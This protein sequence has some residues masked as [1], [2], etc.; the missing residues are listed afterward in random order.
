[1]L[2]TLGPCSTS[3]AVS[4]PAVSKT[5]VFKT[6]ALVMNKSMSLLS[7]ATAS[8]GIQKEI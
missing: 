5:D 8:S 6:D 7:P 4:F 1:M 2:L 3:S